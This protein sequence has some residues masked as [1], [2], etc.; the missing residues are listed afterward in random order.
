ME[1]IFLGTGTSQGVPMIACDCAV[2]TSADPRN[3]RTRASI[4]VVMDGLHVQV[5]AAPEFRLQCLREDIR[6]MDF[7]IL[8]HG[9]A[10]HVVGMDDL[11]RFCDLR[12]GT[13]LTVYTTDEGMS[14]V[15]SIFPYAIAERPVT[16]GY[17]AFKL[18]D[19]PG[20][21]DLPQGTIRSTLLPHG[22]INTLGLVFEEKSSGRRLV[23]YN[24]CKRI[25]REAVAL[26]QGADVV[27]LDGLRVEPHPSHMNIEEACAAGREIG[28]KATYLTHLTHGIDHATWSEKLAPQGVQLAY[29]GLRLKV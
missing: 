1:V 3:R 21:M 22:G 8:T 9:H 28:G 26:A 17:A 4:H 14:R 24:D 7:F 15:L 11:R 12:G 13:A 27:V 5:D 16:K 25:P 18:I 20:V 19:M 6:Q 23:Y 10:D 29:D 2:C